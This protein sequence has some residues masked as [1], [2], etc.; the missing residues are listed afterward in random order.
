VQLPVGSSV[1]DHTA[2]QVADGTEE[3]AL[4][5]GDN[6]GPTLLG[7]EA[8]LRVVAEQLPKIVPNMLI[9]KRDGRFATGCM[10]I[11]LEE[12]CNAHPMTCDAASDE[13]CYST[14]LS[15]RTVLC[16]YQRVLMNALLCFIW[17]YTSSVGVDMQAVHMYYL[18]L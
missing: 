18:V 8:A 6:A 1:Y 17:Q 7:M 2:L 9:N 13:T 16:I 11:S 5:N 12:G 10:F 4:D 3:S 14:A 15:V